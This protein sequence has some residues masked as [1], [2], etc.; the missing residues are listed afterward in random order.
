MKYE[1]LFHER[2][3]LSII[4]TGIA[5]KWLNIRSNSVALDRS[6]L[7]DETGLGEGDV[8]VAE[9]VQEIVPDDNI[10]PH[11]AGIVLRRCGYYT[12]P[13]MEE[14]ATMGLDAEGKCMVDTFI[15]GRRG[16]GQVLYNGPLD[17]ANLNLDEI[18]KFIWFLFP[19]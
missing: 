2:L 1:I 6:G 7:L 13:S 14:L 12:I 19:S 3:H 16:Y 11:P 5:D 17:V 4:E 15:I 8:T 10:P 9:E 18:G